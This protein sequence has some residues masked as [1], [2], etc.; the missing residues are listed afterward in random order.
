MNPTSLKHPA[1]RNLLLTAL[2][3]SL[4]IAGCSTTPQEPRIAAFPLPPIIFHQSDEVVAPRVKDSKAFAAFIR[5]LQSRCDS[6]FTPMQP[7]KPQTIDVAVIV[8]PKNKSRIWLGYEFPPANPTRDRA[9]LDKLKRISAPPVEE[10]PVSFSM[11]LLLW[12]ASEPNPR[13]PR[14]LFLPTEWRVAIGTNQ[15]IAIPEG[16]MPKIWPGN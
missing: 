15:S 11:R 5:E 6:Y 8:K 9:L 10:G 12:G 13:S 1:T 7:G 4:S 2:L 14:G 3:L 16:I